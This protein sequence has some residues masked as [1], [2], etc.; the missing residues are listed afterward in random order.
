[1]LEIVRR[2]FP[3]APQWWRPGSRAAASAALL[4]ALLAV[5]SFQS[6]H[7][8]TTPDPRLIDELRD[9][10]LK[11]P[12]CS[13]DCAAVLAADVSIAA[14]RLEMALTVT[15]LDAVGL[16]LPAGNSTWT[17][18]VVEVDRAGGWVQRIRGTRYVS[19]S[20]GRHVVRLEGSLEGIDALTLSFALPPYVVDV[21]AADWDVSGL[22]DRHLMGG[23]LQLARKRVAGAS[24]SASARQEE[25]PPYVRVER[26]FHLSHDWTI[27][28]NVVRVS[29]RTAA[30]AVTLPLLANEAVTTPG[31]RAVDGRLSLAMSEDET[32]QTF[33]SILPRSEA[34]ELTAPRDGAHSERW[35]FE[36]APTWHAEFSGVPAV[37]PEQDAPDWVFEYY[38]RPGEH[39]KVTVTRPAAAAGESLAF[40][41]I[42]LQTSMGKH[43][44]DSILEMTYRSTQ[45]GRQT[46]RVPA[47]AVVTSVSSDGRPTALRP[48][49]GSSRCLRSRGCTPGRCS[50][51]S[52]RASEF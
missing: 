52:R 16:A 23:V 44:S 10:L 17:P 30:F 5:G 46:L 20:R 9:R 51:A 37:A 47:D 1:M 28:T 35:S 7:A 3:S 2:E 42:A 36:V 40:D 45:G 24:A 33:S 26:V 31:L 15:A 29:P 43:S 8:A 12:R 39:L 34:L 27:D 11:E 49:A 19:L 21:H 4:L 38:P 50:G 41:G 14:G 22:T 25:F 48:E 18:D 13:P 6:T 32:N